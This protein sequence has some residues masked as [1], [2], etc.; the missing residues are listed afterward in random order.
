MRVLTETAKRQHR[1]MRL[2]HAVTALD[3]REAKKPSYNRY[4][5]PRYMEAAQRVADRLDKGGTV[6]EALSGY[7]GRLAHAM[8]STIE[9][10]KLA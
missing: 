6:E 9:R 8:R 1:L 5:L 7:H 4:A 2:L 3:R 10:E